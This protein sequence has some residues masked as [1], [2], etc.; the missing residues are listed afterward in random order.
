V[1]HPT[2]TTTAA[3]KTYTEQSD[4]HLGAK[5]F[6]DN[7]GRA[8]SGDLPSSLPYGT[9]VEVSCWE[10]NESGGMPSV[11]GFYRIES[12]ELAGNVVV[13]DSMTNGGP[14]GNTDSENR[15]PRVGVC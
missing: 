15:D 3:P 12:G 2:N 7:Y 6:A 1:P 10:P 13:A 14:L 8:V 9:A 4:N 11:T 5:V